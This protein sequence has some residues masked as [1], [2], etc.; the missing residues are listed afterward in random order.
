MINDIHFLT[1]RAIVSQCD[2]WY[3]LVFQH[4]YHM[5]LRSCYRLRTDNE[6]TSQFFI[7]QYLVC[8]LQIPSGVLQNS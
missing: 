3:L 2:G 1:R 6:E 7:L 5:L 4:E 8:D